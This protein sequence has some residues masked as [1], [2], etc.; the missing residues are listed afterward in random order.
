[1]DGYL[2]S[3]DVWLDVFW[4][5]GGVCDIFYLRFVGFLVLIWVSCNLLYDL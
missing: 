1:M 5:I 3:K 4:I 2:E